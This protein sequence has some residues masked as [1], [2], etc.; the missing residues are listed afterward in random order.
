LSYIPTCDQNY[1]ICG[2]IWQPPAP[3]PIY[4]FS[5]PPPFK[6]KRGLCPLLNTPLY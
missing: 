3:T 1:S 5:H 6:E 2:V 4:I